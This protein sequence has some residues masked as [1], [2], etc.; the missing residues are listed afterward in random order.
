[1]NSFLWFWLRQLVRLRYPDVVSINSGELHQILTS[2]EP[3]DW[4][5][6]DVRTAAEFNISSLP[7]AV[8]L[9]TGQDIPGLDPFNKSDVE[10]PIL[11]CCSVGWRSAAE[12][13][14]LKQRGFSRA[15]NLEG[16]LFKWVSIGQQLVAQGQPTS[17]V[18]PFNR[19]WGLLLNADSE[20][21]AM[22]HRPCAAATDKEHVAQL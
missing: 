10:Q 22:S 20:V 12:V 11:V 1:M 9:E 17:E 13:N 4:K 5:I 21:V 7:G 8:R 18:H 2:C 15:V 19:F 16:G 3:G 14:R 6:L